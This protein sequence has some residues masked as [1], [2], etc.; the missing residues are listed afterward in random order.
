MSARKIAP[1]IQITEFTSI[2]T[3]DVPLGSGEVSWGNAVVH[4]KAQTA[5]K[6][7]MLANELIG[8]RLAAAIG[9]PVLPGEIASDADGRPCWITPQVLV[10]ASD[11]PPADVESLLKS[12]PDVCAGILVF[13]LWTGNIDRTDENIL[14]EARTG[15]WLI[16]HEHILDGPSANRPAAIEALTPVTGHVF[17]VDE[18]DEEALRMWVSRVENL[19]ARATE[20]PIVEAYNRGLLHA[21]MRDAYKKALRDRRM[22]VRDY[23]RVVRGESREKASVPLLLVDGGD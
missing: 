18:L 4:V 5:D 10:S 13:D 7:V 20:L 6:P 16:D 17:A 9:L 2:A 22:R 21:D 14:Y 11:L 19:A 12:H 8:A 1:G 3:R 15:V 23:I